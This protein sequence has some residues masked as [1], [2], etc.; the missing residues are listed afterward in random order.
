MKTYVFVV[1]S[2]GRIDILLRSNLYKQLIHSGENRAI[3]CSRFSEDKSFRKEFSAPS[4]I[5][6]PLVDLTFSSLAKQVLRLRDMLLKVDSPILRESTLILRGVREHRVIRSVGMRDRVLG[7]VRMLL[8]PMRPALVL[9]FNALESRLLQQPAYVT[10]C[11]QYKPGAVIMGTLG[12]VPDDLVWLVHARTF[13]VPAFAMDLPWNYFEDRMLSLPRPAHVCAW[14][15]AMAERAREEFL[16]PKSRVHV[17]GCVRYDFY[18][19]FIP[20][21]RTEYTKRLGINPDRPY[22]AYFLGSPPSHCSQELVVEQLLKAI[23]QGDIEGNPQLLIRFGPFEKPAQAYIDLMHTYKDDLIINVQEDM[24]TQNDVANIV[25]HS[26]VTLSHFSSLAL[27][28]AVL[29]KAHFYV[30]FSGHPQPNHDD[31]VMGRLFEFDFVKQALATNG[32]QVAYNLDMLTTFIN[33]G[34]KE[35]ERYQVGHAALIEH[36]LGRMDG[37]VGERIAKIITERYGSTS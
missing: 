26:A 32:I 35:P 31:T 13:G 22:I 5:H 25:T 3:I 14:N 34:M 20:A 16:M 30:G 29:D 17:T 28:A 27:D 6:V 33:S 12:V 18:Q 9:F 36:Y 15:D 11:T 2:K 4:V 37:K 10:V 7:V 23:R 8:R 21:S 19:T 1:P 24:P